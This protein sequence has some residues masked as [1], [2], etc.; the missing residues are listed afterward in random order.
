MANGL[1]TKEVASQF[2]ITGKQLRRILRSFERYS[3][4]IYTRYLL[5]K[6]DIEQVAKRLENKTPEPTPKKAKKETRK[7]VTKPPVTEQST[8]QATQ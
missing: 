7:R 2:N 3:D 5:S 4:G 6:R 1:T 8:E